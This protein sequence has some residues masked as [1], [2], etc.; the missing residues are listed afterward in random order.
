MRK[1]GWESSSEVIDTRVEL[2]SV[3]SEMAHLECWV[4][5]L[6]LSPLLIP[7]QNKSS[8]EMGWGRETLV[9]CAV[10]AE[11]LNMDFRQRIKEPRDMPGIALAR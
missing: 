10:T 11:V 6:S 5:F 9:L 7:F 1:D 8:M 2:S 4:S 3:D